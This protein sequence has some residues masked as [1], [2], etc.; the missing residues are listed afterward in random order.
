MK[1][2]EYFWLGIF[3]SFSVETLD[4]ISMPSQMNFGENLAQNYLAELLNKSKFTNI[5]FL[6][7]VLSYA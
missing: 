4:N 6:V 1:L 2:L 3:F 7:H 5:N